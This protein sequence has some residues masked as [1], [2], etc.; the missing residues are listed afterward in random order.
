ADVIIVDEVSM[1]GLTLMSQLLQATEPATKV[2]L[3]GDKDQL[4]S[5]EAGA[6]LGALVPSDVQP[7]YSARLRAEL[8]KVCEGLE[9]PA[10]DRR[11]P[12]PDV[13]VVLEKNYRSQRT[14]QETGRA[15]NRQDHELAARLPRLAGPTPFAELE[16]KQGAWLLEQTNMAV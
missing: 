13:L 16:Q 11:Q 9:M 15:V 1:V 8:G 4:P 6:V 10:N 14:I 7:S 2:I 5:V 3:L 12:L